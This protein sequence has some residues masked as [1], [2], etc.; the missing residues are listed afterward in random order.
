MAEN[1]FMVSLHTGLK[2]LAEQEFEQ[3]S[4]VAVDMAIK[5]GAN[6]FNRYD[7][8]LIDWKNQ[9]AEGDTDEDDLRWLLQARDDLVNLDSLK[10]EGL[11]KVA[12]DRFISGLIEVIVN[13]AKA[14]P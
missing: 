14:V 13:A 7:A 6:F 8:E 5:S 10:D 12:L 4:S 11:A 2:T 9:L 1:D 3:Y